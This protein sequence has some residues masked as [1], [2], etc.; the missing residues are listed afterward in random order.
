MRSEKVAPMIN[1]V[2]SDVQEELKGAIDLSCSI[3]PDV[4]TVH[5]NREAFIQAV[6][7]Q[8][9]HTVGVLLGCEK[10]RIEVNVVKNGT[11]V[12]FMFADNR[13]TT[14]CE[15]NVPER[16]EIFSM[17]EE[18]LELY[19]CREIMARLNG[20]LDIRQESTTGKVITLTLP[21]QA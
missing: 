21:E 13:T 1:G 5:T 20:S 9:V 19:M 2:L 3:A 18:T 6:L 15:G 16:C 7:I 12:A 8:L 11:H 10:A 4:N 14:I 17:R